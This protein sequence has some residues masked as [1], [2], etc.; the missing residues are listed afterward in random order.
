[1]VSTK[2]EGGRVK[3]YFT[4]RVWVLLIVLLLG[5][6]VLSPN[7]WASGIE[8]VSVD[9]SSDASQFGLDSGQKILSVNG[10]EVTTKH[11]VVQAL[12]LLE[13]P[14]Q[15][16]TV[17]SSNGTFRYT[18]TNDLGFLVDENLTVIQST[19]DVPKG[20]TLLSINGEGISDADAFTDVYEA[21]IP[22]N[23]IKIETDAGQIAYLS[24]ETPSFVVAEAKKTNLAFG[25]DFTGGTRVLLQPVSEE[26]ITDSDIT[27]LIDVLSN[28][29]NVYGLS[30]I[31]I[32]SASDW[33]GHKYVLV[34]LAGVTEEEVRDLISQQGKFEAKVGEDV[35]FEGGKEDIPY[36]CRNDGS[37]S[38]IRNCQQNG[39]SSWACSF[40]F[41]ITLSQD[42]AKT[43][44]N[45]TSVLDVVSENGQRYL[46]KPL[47][48]YLDGQ[49]VDS[50]LISENLKGQATTSISISGPGYGSSEISALED[51]TANMNTLQT[52]LIT[53]SLPFDL[54]IVKLDTISPVMGESFLRNTLLVAILSVIAVA[55][56]I[57]V[58]YRQL[59]YVF[60]V[61]FTLLTELFLI[62]SFAAAVGWN[63]DIAALAGI[64]AAI[65]TGVDD[66]IVI[67]DEAVRGRKENTN[68][69]ERLKRA[70]FIIFAAYATTVVAMLP[71]WNAGAG[72]LRGFALTTIAGVTIGVFLTRP[73]FASL[74]E[75]ME[76]E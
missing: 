60:P 13:Y 15:E 55:A 57:F 76:K 23:T 50:L 12:A 19:V 46:S 24:R 37:C 61:M 75:K 3:Q 56:V 40:D 28:R 73:A 4:W 49:L 34:E 7:P 69:Q 30:D 5:A 45:A 59:K 52:I 14:E 22:K 36:V 11:D 44:A 71:L 74:I 9:A 63:L 2:E 68:T 35:V 51:A 8:I 66:Q 48:L 29:L 54:E 31:K 47:D 17:E 26:E 41:T 20:S 42:A 43:Q 18:V 53:G 70:F 58:R 16:V 27:N 62:L 21:L 65:G 32:R 25:L 67:L 64:L 33:E 72:L 6:V 1:M 10:Q 38:G 39:E